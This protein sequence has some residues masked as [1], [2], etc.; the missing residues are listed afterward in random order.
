MAK[1]L[2]KLKEVTKIMRKLTAQERTQR[3][4]K[5]KQ[6]GEE[7]Q[8]LD[9]SFIPADER[10]RDYARYAAIRDGYDPDSVLQD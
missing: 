9:N 7:G 3:L 1:K 8:E 2:K 10:N 5:Y 4:A 6:I